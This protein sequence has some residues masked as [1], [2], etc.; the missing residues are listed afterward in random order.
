MHGVELLGVVQVQIT[1]NK[2]KRE[3]N[4]RDD[5]VQWVKYLGKVYSFKGLS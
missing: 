5:A 2:Q 4:N 1:G 3:G